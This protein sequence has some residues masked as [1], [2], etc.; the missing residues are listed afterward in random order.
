MKPPVARSKTRLR[1]IFGLK[2]KSKLSSVL[3]AIAEA[4]LFAPAFQQPV[5]AARQFVGDQTREQIDGRHRFGLGLMQARFQH[6][7][8]AAETELAQA[9]CSSLRFIRW[10]SWL[11]W[12]V[13]S[14]MRSRYRVS[15]RMSGS[16]WRRLRAG[17]GPFQ[18]AAHEAIDRRAPLPRPRRRPRR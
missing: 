4:G 17:C 14:S 13:R 12:S 9:R 2:V 15:W 7:G 1:F 10:F 11:W 5:G 3:L 8:H 16:T 6:G 18:L